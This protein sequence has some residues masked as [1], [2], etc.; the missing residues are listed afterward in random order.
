M[1]PRTPCCEQSRGA[2]VPRGPREGAG[3]QRCPGGSC[4]EARCWRLAPRWRLTITSC[5]R[6]GPGGRQPCKV[7]HTRR[8]APW[9][10][11]PRLEVPASGRATA[12]AACA[13]H[14]LKACFDSLTIRKLIL[15]GLR[16]KLASYLPSGTSGVRTV[17]PVR[18]L[19]PL[20]GPVH[21]PGLP[22]T[23]PGALGGELT[24]LMVSFLA[25]PGPQ[26]ENNYLF[27]FPVDFLDN[28]GIWLR[29]WALACTGE[30]PRAGREVS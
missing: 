11:E 15:W 8:A 17:L 26:V 3:S 24:A 22:R 4:P 2:P 29:T 7:G 9:G 25:F 1:E 21:A 23:L 27:I 12:L 30:V 16:W 13:G 10:L 6:E 19:L 14:L 20:G 28:A 18:A 5:V